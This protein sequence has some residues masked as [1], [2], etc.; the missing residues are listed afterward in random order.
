MVVRLD[1]DALVPKLLAGMELA[2]P[3]R[4]PSYQLGSKQEA[5]VRPLRRHVHADL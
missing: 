3:T 4:T 1:P 5:M 2:E